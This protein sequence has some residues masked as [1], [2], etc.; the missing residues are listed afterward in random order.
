M[1]GQTT[2]DTK[3]ITNK[4]ISERIQ[5]A[6]DDL[7]ILGDRTYGREADMSE[8]M[9]ALLYM[10]TFNIW[11]MQLQVMKMVKKKPSQEKQDERNMKFQKW[12][13]AQRDEHAGERGVPE[14]RALATH[15][16][17]LYNV[18]VG[19]PCDASAS[20]FMHNAAW[21]HKKL[22]AGVNDG[23][24]VVALIKTYWEKMDA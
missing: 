5:R 19:P 20:A 23:E 16:R 15:Y 14:F 22:L 4:Q 7:I 24:K 1:T 9:N 18:A 6:L 13:A 10:F 12:L 21:A 17:E 11:A 8:V 2:I 3:N